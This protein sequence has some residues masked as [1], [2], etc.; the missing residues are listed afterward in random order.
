MGRIALEMKSE[1]FHQILSHC[2]DSRPTSFDLVAIL[3]TRPFLALDLG[4][5]F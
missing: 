3:A 1:Y 2:A 4:G 5:V